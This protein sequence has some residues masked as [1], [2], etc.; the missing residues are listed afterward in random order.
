[1]PLPAKSAHL[2]VG[3]DGSPSSFDPVTNLMDVSC[4]HS[5]SEDDVST[6]GSNGFAALY[7]AGAQ[8]AVTIS[9]N[10]VVETTVASFT[11]LRA[12]AE[13]T[14]DNSIACQFDDGA[15]IV[16]G[17]FQVTSW[18]CSAP[19]FGHVNFSVSLRSTG[20]YTVTAS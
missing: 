10:G 5:H 14:S 3:T 12:A 8:H 15:F 13:S 17:V 2:L 4:S 20:T 11:E 6:K 7:A 9:G 16:E 1:M 18:E 19:A